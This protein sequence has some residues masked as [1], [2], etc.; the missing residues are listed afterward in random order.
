MFGFFM[1]F[2]IVEFV[3]GV[4]VGVWWGGMIQ[5]GVIF[6]FW[7][8]F[9]WVK[10]FFVISWWWSL[11]LLVNIFVIESFM[12][13]LVLKVG[14][15]FVQFCL[16]YIQ[17]D[18]AGYCLCEVIKVV[19]EK[20]GWKDEVVN[21]WVMGFV[22]FIDVWIFCVQV[23]EVLIENGE[24]KVYKVICVIDFGIVVNFDQVW[25]QCEGSIIMGQSVVMYECMF[26]KDG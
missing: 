15:D 6:N 26:V 4:D 22:V 13:E 8:V 16:E 12:D 18:E 1:F 20:V 5:Y 9:W 7:M 19:V 11:G 17:E 24:I 10:F 25:V 14:K 3:L 23:V 21:G 2:G